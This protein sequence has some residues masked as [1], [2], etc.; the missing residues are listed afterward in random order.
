MNSVYILWHVNVD[1]KDDEKLI[2]GL[3]IGGRCKSGNRASEG[4]AWV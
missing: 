1:G 2:G 4:Q 3:P